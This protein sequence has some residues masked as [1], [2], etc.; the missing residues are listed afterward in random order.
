MADKILIVDDEPAMRR[1]LSI[2]LRHEDY[3]V[4]DAPDGR[5]ALEHLAREG[6]D[7]VMVDLRMDGLSG[8]DVLRQVKQVSPDVEV[9]VMTGYGTI[10]AAVDAMR[11][12]A[13]DFITKPFEMEQVLLRVKNALE[14]RHL[15][16][17]VHQ[18]RAE[19]TRAFSLEAIVGKSDA[20]RRVL[21]LVPR[22]AHTD[23]TVLITGESGT[24][25][26]LVARAIH[27]VSRRIGGPF[28]AVSC[29]ALPDHLLESELFGHAKG[30]FTSAASARKG[31][32]EDAQSGTFFLD[33]VG[34]TS[35]EIQR[36]LLRVIEERSMRRL[37]DNRPIALDIRLVAA[38][39]RD[40][41][42][43]V[44]ARTTSTTA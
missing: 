37:G 38:T 39:N 32:L 30:A 1:S 25:K 19:A 27:G 43:A 7:L 15:K 2:M 8:L 23:S 12:G 18:L 9:I 11:F 22:A 36:K 3:A 41:Q 10:E 29:A 35:L 13:F 5:A 44:D 6:V 14:R 28:V 31:L 20:M 26:E 16:H 24:G 17:E 42:E 40:L 21:D 33:E 34:D 4:A